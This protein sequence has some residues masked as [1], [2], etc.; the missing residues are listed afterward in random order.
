MNLRDLEVM[1]KVTCPVCR[2]APGVQCRSM[3]M[4]RPGVMF[5]HVHK[6]REDELRALERNI[7]ISHK[8]A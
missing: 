7:W 2:A 8:N 1:S 5:E 3:D 4:R 6:G